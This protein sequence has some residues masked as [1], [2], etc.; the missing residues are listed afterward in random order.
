MR[1]AGWESVQAKKEEV[2]PS[3]MTY[4]RLISGAYSFVLSEAGE[5]SNVRRTGE[6]D[7]PGMEQE[8]SRTRVLAVGRRGARAVPVNCTIN[9]SPVP[10]R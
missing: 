9:F 3:G 5:I 10:G 8:L 4:V 7:I 6:I 2:S 1:A